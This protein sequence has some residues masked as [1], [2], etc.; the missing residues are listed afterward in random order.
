MTRL[1]GRL[2]IVD[3]WNLNQ[4]ILAEGKTANL[5]QINSRIHGPCSRNVLET[6]PDG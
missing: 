2:N 3:P 6:D 5:K 1:R 4:I